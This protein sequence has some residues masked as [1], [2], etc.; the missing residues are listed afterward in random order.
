MHRRARLLV[1]A[2]VG[3][4]PLT[5]SRSPLTAQA[6]RPRSAATPVRLSVAADGN[7]VR[8]VVREQL[9][10]F[11]L[12]NDAI[13]KTS[14]ITGGILLDGTGKVDSSGSKIVVDLST[15]KSDKDRRDA[16]IKRR[17]IVVDSFPNATL[18]VTELRGLPAVLP[19][20]G[21]LTLTLV[22]NF[23]VHGVT[24]PLT[25]QVEAT[26][27]GDHF[28][29]KASTRIKF[30]DFNMTQPKVPIV[31]SV[32]DDILLEYDFHLVK[33]PAARP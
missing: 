18:T 16:F 14:A 25:W 33:E 8:Y 21:K 3:L 10:G 12:P 28:T 4:F 7:E 1:L 30:G 17:T 19:T 6:P 32:V 9:V 23:T 20:S 11:E 13:G 22:G 24:K 15:L 26:A 29:G 5:A 31:M 27:N 2:A